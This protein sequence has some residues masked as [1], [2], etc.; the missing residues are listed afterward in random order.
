MMPDEEDSEPDEALDA[1]KAAI[2][3]TGGSHLWNGWTRQFL[4]LAEN[5]LRKAGIDP[6]TIPVH[7]TVGPER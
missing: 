6:A 2:A 4:I 5:A 1:C 7:E 3:A